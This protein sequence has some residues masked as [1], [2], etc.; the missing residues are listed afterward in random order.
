MENISIVRIRDLWL[1]FLAQ[2]K[3]L[4]DLIFESVQSEWCGSLPLSLLSKPVDSIIR[5]KSKSTCHFH[6][7]AG[8][9]AILFSTVQFFSL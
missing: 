1:S 5:K 2:F 4:I 3:L 8:N 6:C 7:V 9:S